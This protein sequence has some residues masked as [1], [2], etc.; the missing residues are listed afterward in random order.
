LERL[1]VRDPAIHK[2]TTEVAHLIKPRSVYQDPEIMQ[3]VTV[4]MATMAAA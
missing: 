3:R 1:A 4:E 2:L